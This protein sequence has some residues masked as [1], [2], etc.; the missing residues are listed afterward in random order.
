MSKARMEVTV[1]FP[2]PQDEEK[3]EL[4]RKKVN[5]LVLGIGETLSFEPDTPE[6]SISSKLKPAVH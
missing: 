5:V 4:I 2:W 1:E 3:R 6:I